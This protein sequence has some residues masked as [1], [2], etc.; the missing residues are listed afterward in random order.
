MRIEAD[1]FLVLDDQGW[2]VG[3]ATRDNILDPPRARLILVDHNDLAQAVRGAE[4][5]EIVAVLDHHQLGDLQT[6]VPIPIAIEPVGSTS[7]LVA[8]RCREQAPGREGLLWEGRAAERGCMP[9]GLAGMLLSGLLSDTL[10]FRSPTTTERD[11]AAAA[12]LAGLSRVEVLPYGEELLR[13]G[14][15]IAAHPAGEILNAD[16]KSYQI[17]GKAVSIGQVEVADMHEL[18]SRREEILAALEGRRERESLGLMCLMITD[19]MAGRSRL[20]CRG[21]TR[22]LTLL[23]FPRSGEGEFDLG[24]MLSRKQQLLPALHAM[25]ET[26]TP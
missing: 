11:R 23:Q 1:D 8:E 21:E 20:L 9:L 26:G 19:V 10:V 22:L 7:T 14:S 5:A 24:E 12:W 2:Y 17:G 25:L 16:R 13:A 6:P 3:I 18:A 4:E 15:R